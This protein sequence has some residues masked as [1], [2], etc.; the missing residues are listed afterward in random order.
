[1]KQEHSWHDG[2]EQDALIRLYCPMSTFTRTN[3]G[4]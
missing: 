3:W 1:M 4:A 2:N